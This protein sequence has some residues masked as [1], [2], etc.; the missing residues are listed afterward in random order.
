MVK[1][2]TDY[3]VGDGLI[4]ESIKEFTGI[5]R[6]VLPISKYALKEKYTRLYD[7][8][9]K[10]YWNGKGILSNDDFAQV[11]YL[12]NLLI[13]SIMFYNYQFSTTNDVG[14]DTKY[15]RKARLKQERLIRA[16]KI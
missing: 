5:E 11:D 16:G 7:R 13:D 1:L 2:N 6:Y 15:L 9:D 8:I 14:K 4:L 10:V 12:M 3:L